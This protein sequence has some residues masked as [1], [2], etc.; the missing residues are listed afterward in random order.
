MGIQSHLFVSYASICIAGRR[1]CGIFWCTTY[2]AFA[3]IPIGILKKSVSIQVE[4]NH[5]SNGVD[6]HDCTPDVPVLEADFPE[7]PSFAGLVFT[8]YFH[9]GLLFFFLLGISCFHTSSR[10]ESTAARMV[11]YIVF[12][13][14][15]PYWHRT[16]PNNL[17]E[18]APQLLTDSWFREYFAITTA[19]AGCLAAIDVGRILTRLKSNLLNDGVIKIGKASLGIYAM[20]FYFLVYQP[21]VIALVAISVLLWKI[22]SS[23]P[24]AHRLLFGK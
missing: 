1:I 7:L 20:H 16:L 8:K 3:L 11:P 13:S 5:S 22:S 24:A 12:I 21:L 4:K 10:T 15:A 9:G 23:I 18:K 2:A 17:I 19:T 14:L 6:N